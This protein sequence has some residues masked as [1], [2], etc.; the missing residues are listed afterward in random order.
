MQDALS[1]NFRKADNTGGAVVLPHDNRPLVDDYIA[2]QERQAKQHKPDNYTIPDIT[3]GDD[4]L[5][6]RVWINHV[7]QLTDEKNQIAQAQTQLL[8]ARK[9]G[10][11]S[12]ADYQR[13]MMGVQAQQGAW[14]K[15]AVSSARFAQQA[16][17]AYGQVNQAPELY[18]DEAKQHLDE[19]MNTNSPDEL[20]WDANKI[21]QLSQIDYKPLLQGGVTPNVKTV[22]VVNKDGTT[23]ETVKT[24]V[25]PT[26]LRVSAERVANDRTAK[27]EA[28][29][30]AF[31][32]ENPNGTQDQY[33]DWI[34][35]QKLAENKWT[36]RDSYKEGRAP[37]GQGKSQSLG[38]GKVQINGQDWV[39]R[40][41][42][43]VETT[44][45]TG[46][47]K[48]AKEPRNYTGYNGE[49]VKGVLDHTITDKNGNQMM[50]IN[51][52]VETPVPET[53]TE[54]LLRKVSG[55]KQPVIKEIK[56][57][58]VPY[59]S[60]ITGA[61]VFE[62]RKLA[63]GSID[64]PTDGVGKVK[65]SNT[66]N[67]ATGGKKDVVKKYVNKKEGKTKLVFSDGTEQIVDG[68]E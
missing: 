21:R 44:T 58:N 4:S 8:T 63:T 19:N 24:T 49:V 7:P 60:D 10:K 48:L 45:P 67:K 37:A 59:D 20:K 32:Q 65:L 56:K 33:V 22:K 41:I 29:H 12:D 27:G 42:D 40:V 46:N 62:I 13:G 15:K 43:G 2:F 28:L 5:L 6:G 55:K 25:D 11:L 50:V 61:N 64:K 31:K 16:S 47:N 18:P 57:I 30:A 51:T 17:S 53:T 52:P 14:L 35:K 54:K 38:D 66:P 39:H 3:K 26:D 68:I 36:I 34:A 1:Q 23:T 9:A